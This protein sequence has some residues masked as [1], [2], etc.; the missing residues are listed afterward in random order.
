MKKNY[1]PLAMKLIKLRTEGMIAESIAKG[2]NGGGTGE[3]GIIEAG[4]NRNT[5]NM[6]WG[7]E[8]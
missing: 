6:I 4:S 3:N 8:D 5:S 7:D 1:S 2:G